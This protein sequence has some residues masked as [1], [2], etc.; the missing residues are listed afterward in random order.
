MGTQK[1]E[2]WKKTTLACLSPNLPADRT[3]QGWREEK[4][5]QGIAT[6][7]LSSI[8]P[9]CI[10]TYVFPEHT[11]TSKTITQAPQPL[12]QGYAVPMAMLPTH[13]LRKG[14]N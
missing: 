13:L 7:P 6:Y 10:R 5:E 11:G 2:F 12:S 8:P 3:R 9:P 14:Q 1:G 4:E